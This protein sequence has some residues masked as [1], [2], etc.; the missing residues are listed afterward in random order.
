MTPDERRTIEELIARYE[1]EPTLRDVYVEGYSDSLFFRWFLQKSDASNVVV[2]EIDSVRIDTQT[3][4][5]HRLEVGNRGRLIAFALEVDRRITHPHQVT[6]IV[7]RDYD[8][9]LQREFSVGVLL[10]T[11]YTSLELYSFNESTLTKFLSIVAR[12]MPERPVILLGKF[13][14]ILH[15]T[16]FIRLVNIKLEL[17]AEWFEFTRCCE[18]RKGSL[19]F[20]SAEFV[21]RYLNKNGL[22]AIREVFDQ[23]LQEFRGTITDEP[24]DFIRGHDFAV[25][26]AYY[27]KQITGD[28]FYAPEM[29]EGS[30]L[31]CVEYEDLLNEKMFQ[32][33]LHRILS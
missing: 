5:K 20:D 18:F 23:T 1:L 19:E 15:E 26:L 28:Q 32:N 21:K 24:R 31:G 3:V 17:N 6:C 4:L 2:Y 27:L 14:S 7:D 29:V 13:C 16:F 22:H 9:P 11:D 30:L 10:F 25:L 8:A 33:L 12:T